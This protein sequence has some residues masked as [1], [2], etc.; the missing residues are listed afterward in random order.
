MKKI[1]I[2][3]QP[4]KNDLENI[5]RLALSCDISPVLAEILYFRG[6]TDE[7][8]LKSFLNPREQDFNSPFDLADMQAVVERIKQAKE[9]G[10]TVMIYGDYDADGISATTVLYKSLTGFG[11]TAE[12][13]VPER[14]DGYGLSLSVLERAVDEWTEKGFSYPDLLITVDCGIGDRE[15]IEEIKNLGIDVIVTDHHEIP[16]TLPDTLVVNPKRKDQK[17]P[18]SGLCGCAVAYKVAYALTGKKADEYL[19][20]VALAT[21]ADS[22]PL[23]D[24]NRAIVY[25]GLK[26]FNSDKIRPQYKKLLGASAQRTVTSSNLAYL[27]AP[28]INASGRMGN[29]NAGLRYFM[30]EDGS[31]MTD[32]AVLLTNYNTERQGECEKMYSLAKE[33]L[34][35]TGAYGGA[36]V[37][38]DKS[39]KTGFAGIVSAKLTEEFSRPS[40]VFAGSG[41]GIFKGSCRSCDGINIFEALGKCKEFVVDYGGH[42]QAAGVSVTEENYEKF[43]ETFSRVIEEECGE[44]LS[45]NAVYCDMETDE[46][47]DAKLAKE[48][49]RI[50]PC[51]ADNRK[52]VIVTTGVCE[53]ISP[54]KNG[55]P[56][57]VFKTKTCDMLWFNAISDVKTLNYP[58]EKKIIFEPTYSVFGGKEYVKGI[59]KEVIPCELGID[60]LNTAC[61]FGSVSTLINGDAFGYRN[62]ER[63]NDLTELAVKRYGVAFI[64]YNQNVLKEYPELKGL[65]RDVFAPPSKNLKTAVILAPYDS[66]VLEDYETFVFLDRPYGDYPVPYGKKVYLGKTFNAEKYLDGA[67]FSRENMAKIYGKIKSLAGKTVSDAYGAYVLS[68][69]EGSIAEFTVGYE[70]FAEL[71][72]FYT[73]GGVLRINGKARAQLD[74]S[75]FYGFAK[76]V[77]R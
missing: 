8:K 40:I 53:G 23:T 25:F 16:E 75:E 17:Y 62:K 27:I 33:Q 63:L 45:E 46:P 20:L 4:N 29:A 36:I 38:A 2:A 10:E 39:W 14:E 6:Y 51:G 52:P 61:E 74:D 71:K 72:F 44:S 76:K 11:I 21:V 66:A 35:R 48:L 43:K 60:D 30:T 22:M 68:G 69:K 19:D 58:G 13:V 37:V 28:K 73:E 59:V 26:I 56:H 49:E 77:A 1:N 15:V 24:E 12:Y 57:V 9:K 67:D 42:A 65:E 70:T 5:S 31:E 34:K 54:L 32:L 3:C 64:A 50:E 18:F 7:K 41:D 47:I 55:S